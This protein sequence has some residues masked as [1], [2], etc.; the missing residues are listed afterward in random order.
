VRAKSH[1]PHVSDRLT[2][3][4]DLNHW[5]LESISVISAM[6]SGKMCAAS[7]VMSSNAARRRVEDL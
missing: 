7:A 3:T 4:F 5:R 2:P 1:V 6:D